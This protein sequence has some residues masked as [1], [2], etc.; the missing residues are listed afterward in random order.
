MD[1][2][3]LESKDTAALLREIAAIQRQ[4]ARIGRIAV[5]AG[6]VL[7]VVLLVSLILIVP[8]L[9]G[10]LDQAHTTLGDLQ[11]TIQHLNASLDTLDGLGEN[12]KTFS[13]EST[14]TLNKLLNTLNAVD[15]DALTRSNQGFNSVIEGL[16]NFRLFG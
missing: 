12:L 15:L 9:M 7:A 10:T 6:I 1:N 13:D 2:N 4:N 11:Q 16:S 14:E 3:R 8:K 5:A